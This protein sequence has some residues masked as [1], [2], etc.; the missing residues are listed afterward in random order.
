MVIDAGEVE[1]RLAMGA[2][3]SAEVALNAVSGVVLALVNGLD[4]V[5]GAYKAEPDRGVIAY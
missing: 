4:V 2:P 5:V 1:A 3:V